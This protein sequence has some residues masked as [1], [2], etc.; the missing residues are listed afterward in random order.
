MSD[1]LTMPPLE[2]RGRNGFWGATL[3][4]ERLTIELVLALAFH[5][6]TDHIVQ[7]IARELAAESGPTP[8]QQ[9]GWTV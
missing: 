4:L 8:D 5:D 6:P 3:E 9:T 1:L 7:A 2:V